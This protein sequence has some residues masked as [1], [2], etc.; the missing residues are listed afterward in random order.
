MRCSLHTPLSVECG[1]LFLRHRLH[2]IADQAAVPALRY[3]LP[4]QLDVI[5]DDVVHISLDHAVDAASGVDRPGVDLPA[6]PVHAGHQLRRDAGGLHAEMI[7]RG[8]SVDAPVGEAGDVHR[9]DAL[10][11]GLDPLQHAVDLGK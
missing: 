3:A 9:R 2:Q 5:R 7:R 8:Q 6:L 4:R 10:V 11:A 1:A